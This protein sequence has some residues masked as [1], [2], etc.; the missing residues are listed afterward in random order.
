MPD[1]TDRGP[2][3]NGDI[4]AENDG[5]DPDRVVFVFGFVA[6]AGDLDFGAPD[7]AGFVLGLELEFVLPVEQQPR[8]GVAV[9]ELQRYVF[10]GAGQMHGELHR[11]AGI[12]RGRVGRAHDNV[13]IRQ[14]HRLEVFEFRGMTVGIERQECAAGGGK[15]G[16]FRVDIPHENAGLKV[17]DLAVKTTVVAHGAGNVF[18][19]GQDG[20]DFID[21]PGVIGIDRS[22]AA[23]GVF[24]VVGRRDGESRSGVGGG[25]RDLVVAPAGNGFAVFQ[26]EGIG[27][28]LDVKFGEQST[29]AHDGGAGKR[30]NTHGEKLRGY[31]WVRS[32]PALTLM[33]D[34]PLTISMAVPLVMA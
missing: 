6:E 16:I 34:L 9:V 32:N 8:H 33:I 3:G 27:V 4:A 17:A 2:D 15:F 19:V 25:E 12:D 21:D 29:A 31:C 11:V 10:G 18:G 1:R 20:G 14:F 23:A 26:P 7:F 13:L 5:L 30:E 22:A 24:L 28:G